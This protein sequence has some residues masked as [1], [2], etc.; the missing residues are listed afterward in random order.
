[1]MERSALVAMVRRSAVAQVVSLGLAV[2]NYKVKVVAF[3]SNS[4]HLSDKD[5][6]LHRSQKA[7]QSTDRCVSG[8]N[9]CDEAEAML[10]CTTLS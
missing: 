7:L 3:T 5:P 9:S 2:A 6:T 8:A 1:M 4:M 10:N